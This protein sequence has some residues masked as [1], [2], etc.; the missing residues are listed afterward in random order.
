MG[1]L[2]RLKASADAFTIVFRTLVKDVPMKALTDLLAEL[3]DGDEVIVF[4][5]KPI[6]LPRLN[7][8][9]ADELIPSRHHKFRVK[10]VKVAGGNTERWLVKGSKGKTFGAHIKWW[11]W[12]IAQP[13]F[14]TTLHPTY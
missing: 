8:R 2:E 12:A 9:L 11:Q 5:R 13:H 10:D 7:T 4:N 3:E 1:K 14:R 6:Y